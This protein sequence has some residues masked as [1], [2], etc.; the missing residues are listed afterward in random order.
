MA[1]QLGFVHTI[2][3]FL[4]SCFDWNNSVSNFYHAHLVDKTLY[5][6][7]ASASLTRERNY[8]LPPKIHTLS[9]RQG[10]FH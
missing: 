9:N 2:K 7:A 5:P 6:I 3:Y 8:I 10:K 4:K 1:I